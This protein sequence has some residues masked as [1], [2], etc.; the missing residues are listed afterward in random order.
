M[1]LCN[2][3]MLK[4]IPSFQFTLLKNTA[5][6]HIFI[7]SNSPV[8]VSDVRYRSTYECVPCIIRAICIYFSI[9]TITHFLFSFNACHFQCSRSLNIYFGWSCILRLGCNTI[10][11]SIALFAAAA[12]AHAS[13]SIATVVLAF[14]TSWSFCL[15]FSFNFFFASQWFFLYTHSLFCFKSNDSF[16]LFETEK[17][18]IKKELKS[19]KCPNGAVT[20]SIP[21]LNAS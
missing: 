19:L 12:I 7:H 11:F 1:E 9:Q 15:R 8:R 2:L 21:Q 17:K 4:I 14:S 3:Q 16:W 18:R 10:F 6:T 5:Q 13:D 20:Q